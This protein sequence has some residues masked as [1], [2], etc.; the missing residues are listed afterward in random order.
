[1]LT[2][3]LKLAFKVLGRRKLFTFISLF[4]VSLTLVVLMT[5]T[6]ILENLFGPYAPETHTDRTL[7]VFTVHLSGPGMEITGA[8]GYGLLNRTV[9]DLPGAETVSIYRNVEMTTAYVHG[10]KVQTFLKRTDGA[11]WR[12]LDFAFIE[13][14]PYGDDDELRGNHVAVINESTRRNW[15]GDAP[16]VGGTVSYDGESYRVVGVVRN[17]GLF[18]DIPFADVWVPISTLKTSAWRDDIRGDFTALILGRD[19][20]SLPGIREEFAARIAAFPLPDP[21][22]MNRIIAAAETR[23]ESISSNLFAGDER[24]RGAGR[25]LLIIIGAMV[26]FMLLPTINLVNINVS[27]ILERAGEIGVR[28]AFGASSRALVGQFIVENVLLCLMGGVIG[29]FLSWLTLAA[30]NR[31]GVIPYADF[32]MNFRVLLWGFLLTL[33]FGVFSGVYPAF[34]M[35]RLHPVEALRK[36]SR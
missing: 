10:R 35:S 36:A 24:G 34:R 29:L 28:K 9:R 19:R 33:F 4:G 20:S 3:Y 1:M 11:Y 13:G 6:A 21:K 22:T 27:R 8:A 12:I 26:A 15:F 30:I 5:A 16:A 18:R 31:T 23:F 2:N 17:V 14:G 32:H 25:L 7:G